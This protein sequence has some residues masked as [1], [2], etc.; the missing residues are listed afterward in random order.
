MEQQGISTPRPLQP[1]PSVGDSVFLAEAGPG[2]IPAELHRDDLAAKRENAVQASEF[3][4][5]KLLESE[6]VVVSCDSALGTL[7]DQLG[8]ATPGQ[9]YSR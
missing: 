5:R 8:D 6:A 7:K 9:T 4:R 2:F 1:G 3:H